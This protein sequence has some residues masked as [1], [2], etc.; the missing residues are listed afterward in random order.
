MGGPRDLDNVCDTIRRVLEAEPSVLVGY[1]FGSVAEGRDGP[2]S[3]VD[4][5]VLLAADP[6]REIEGRLLDRLVTELRTDRVDLVSLAR[7]PA[8]LR[9]R[10]VRGGRRLLCRD[11]VARER[12]EVRTVLRYLDFQP[13]RDRALRAVRNAI[14]EGS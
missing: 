6:D 14:L 3:D 4:V 9:Y 1:L 8:P 12:F 10:V 5:A 2:L 11:E 13:L 7:A